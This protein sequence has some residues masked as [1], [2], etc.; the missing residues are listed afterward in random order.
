MAQAGKTPLLPVADA[1][2]DLAQADRGAG[3]TTQETGGKPGQGSRPQCIGSRSERTGRRMLRSA[4]D[5]T[6]RR[7]SRATA[8]Q[9]EA[10]KRRFRQEVF[11][12]EAREVRCQT[13]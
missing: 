5:Q 7:L 10:R 1:A 13:E 6:R 12:G 9:V 8:Q 4:G 2:A 3:K 11:L